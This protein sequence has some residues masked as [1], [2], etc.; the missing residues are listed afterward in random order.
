[1]V[2]LFDS[3]DQGQ[4]DLPMTSV[5]VTRD[6]LVMEAAYMTLRISLARGSSGERTG[7]LAQNGITHPIVMRRGAETPALRRPQEPVRPYPYDEREVRFASRAPGVRLAGTM[8]LPRAPGRHPAVVLISGSGA[9]DRDETI[10][11]H[12]PFLVLSDRLTRSGYVVLRV[13]D[14]GTGGSTGSVLNSTLT[15]IAN[16]VRGAVDYLKATAEV[17]TAAIGLIGHSE[18]G[19]VAPIVAA[20]DRSIAFVA[21]LGAPAVSGRAVFSAQKSALLRASGATPRTIRVDSMLTARI[22]SVL[23]ASLPDDS[24]AHAVER[25]LTSWLRSLPA[26]ERAAADSLLR[27]R[28]PAQDSASVEFWKSAWFR[29]VY[30][31]HPAELLRAVDVPLLAVL[32]GLDLQ[33]PAVQSAPAFDRLFQGE[34]RRLLTLQLV[35]GV[36]HMLQTATR[37]TMDEYMRIEET[38]APSVLRHLT[39][40]LSR[41]AP[42]AANQTVTTPR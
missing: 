26:A 30:F 15:D 6:S 5:E 39:E 16:D 28:T 23:D 10:A 13:D 17:D 18:G 32:G 1:M 9:Q 11:G 4:R 40:W 41:V 42:A 37:G 8:T 22:F 31:H 19:Y 27:E 35:P 29:S 14:R 33:V 36:N 38:I 12:K 2:G 25:A 7:T 3:P 21:L 20:G 34:R 24:L